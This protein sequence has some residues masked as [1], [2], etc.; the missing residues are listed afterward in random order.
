MKPHDVH[1]L[2]LEDDDFQR[3]LVNN[4]LRTLGVVDISEAID[5]QSALNLLETTA[6]KPVDIVLC[7]MNMPTMD[8]MEFMRHLGQ[9]KL[10]V[11]IVILSTL[12]RA[13]LASVAEM[14]RAYGV[15]L[16][17]VIE[18]P[19]TLKQLEALIV[20]FE[21]PGTKLPS[22]VATLP[23]FSLDEILQGVREKQFEPF[24]QP[25]VDFQSGKIIGAEALARWI[26]PEYGI[27]SPYAFID[28]LEQNK[29]IDELTF[30]ILKKSV[31]ASRVFV[32]KGYD[33][34]ISVNLSLTSLTDTNL[35]GN[36][37]QV[38]RSL[39]AEPG[40]FVLEVTESA[41]MTD[42]AHALENLARLRMNGFGLSID[43][44]GT[45]YAS[46]QQLTRVAFTEL[47][48]DQSFV[49]GCSSNP[50]LRIVVESSIELARKL[51]VKSV[52][53]G[54][55]TQQ[56]W[57]ELKQLGCDIAQGFFIAKPMSLQDFIEF[58]EAWLLKNNSEKP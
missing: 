21:P 18:K 15:S 46:M 44:Y 29:M 48:V 22:S 23:D 35:A 31:A 1:F 4:M 55:E 47:K 7:D 33:I 41:A 58:Y 24:F 8:G 56:D 5:G 50:A 54:V 28:L 19:I 40:Q 25:K 11:S 36:I 32:E 2:I 45:G 52:A 16:L 13:L 17:S 37:T 38:V 42:I 51:N 9:R 10:P 43:D 26:H 53:E 49:K 34:S 14:S 20:Q 30:A 12:E 27:V 6:S 57:D 39:G 3:K